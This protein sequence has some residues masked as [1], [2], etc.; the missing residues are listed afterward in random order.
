ME[1][2]LPTTIYAVKK[3]GYSA[4]S[5]NGLDNEEDVTLE[6]MID[7]ALEYASEDLNDSRVNHYLVAEYHDENGNLVKTERYDWAGN[8]ETDTEETV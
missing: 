1:K 3:V 2:N 5:L 8:K 6:S 4:D 7:M